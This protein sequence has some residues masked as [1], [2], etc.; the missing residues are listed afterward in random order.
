M[1]LTSLVT[2]TITDVVQHFVTF[3]ML[4]EDDGTLIPYRILGRSE[5]ELRK[6]VSDLDTYDRHPTGVRYGVEVLSSKEGD[7]LDAAAEHAVNLYRRP[8]GYGKID[9]I[10]YLR[11]VIAGTTLRAAVDAVNKYW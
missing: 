8:D 6:V 10:K 9:A 11:S 4:N 7:S 3:N 2:R 1:I 5:A